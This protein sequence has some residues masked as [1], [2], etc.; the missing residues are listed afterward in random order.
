MYLQLKACIRARMQTLHSHLFQLAVDRFYRMTILS[1]FKLIQESRMRFHI[2][3]TDRNQAHSRL[4]QD[5]CFI[6]SA[7]VALIA[8]DTCSC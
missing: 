4:C 3:S 2:C 5:A 7:I 6:I 1:Q 8:E